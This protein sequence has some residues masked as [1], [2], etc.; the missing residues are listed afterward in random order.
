MICQISVKFILLIT[1]TWLHDWMVYFCPQPC[2]T[3]LFWTVCS[4][5]SWSGFGSAGSCDCLCWLELGDGGCICTAAEADCS[6]DILLD[7]SLSRPPAEETLG[8]WGGVGTAEPSRDMFLPPSSFSVWSG[9]VL[10]GRELESPVSHGSSPS[11]PSGS[12]R[13]ACCWSCTLAAEER[14]LT[15]ASRLLLVAVR[16]GGGGGGGFGG[17]MA[18]RGDCRHKLSSK[19]SSCVAFPFNKPSL[20]PPWCANP[21]WCR[22]ASCTL[23]GPPS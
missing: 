15:D 22:L 16:V 10:A 23:H 1:A 12:L 21:N 2:Q 19:S 14:R 5:A 13:A 6:I 18:L 9:F 11:S 8:V 4:V 17:H 3:N 7:R 20:L